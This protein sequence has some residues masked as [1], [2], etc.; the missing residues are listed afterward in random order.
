MRLI[1]LIAPSAGLRQ[2]DLLN[3]NH[4]EGIPFGAKLGVVITADCDLAQ[5][6]HYGQVLL[7]PI[8]PACVYYEYIWC[9]KRLE[10]FKEKAL[11]RLRKE[12]DELSTRGILASPLS[13]LALDA[14]CKSDSAIRSSLATL[15]L[16]IGKIEELA[17][18]VASLEKCQGEGG[19]L[20]SLVTASAHSQKKEASEVRKRMFS[21]FKA[22][23]A[24]D[25]IDIVAIHDDLTGDDIVHIVLLRAPFSVPVE[26][27]SFSSSD[28][29]LNT[30][31]RVGTFTP[32]V[33][34]LI[35]QK[36]GTLFSRVGMK[37]EIEIDRDAAIDLLRDTA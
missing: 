33:K 23:L 34:F 1:N 27:I 30:Y 21:D 16:P 19:P 14:I 3:L 4:T 10:N 12:F 13:D 28:K 17:G 22:E 8:I 7:C 15:G 37:G 29:G 32:E 26:S 20:I 5:D 36:F 31:V 24:R 6:K 18:I 9:A 35:A 25:A 11:A 2:G